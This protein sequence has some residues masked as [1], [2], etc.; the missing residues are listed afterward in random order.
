MS[1]P[2]VNGGGSLLWQQ[3]GSPGVTR[4]PLPG[5]V[6]ADV[7]IVGGGFTGLWTAYYLKRAQ[8]DLRIVVLEGRFVGYG[9]SGRNGG[10]LTNTVTGGREQYERTHGRDSA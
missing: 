3:L 9:A 8:P 10:W 4:S 2:I 6:E 5:S 1:V 7:C